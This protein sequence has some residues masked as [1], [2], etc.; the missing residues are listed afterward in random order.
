MVLSDKK[1]LIISYTFPPNDGIGGR[2]WAKFAKY[3]LRGGGDIF[4]FTSADTSAKKSPWTKDIRA[5]QEKNRIIKVN[6]PYPVVLDSYPS[7]IWDKIKY[8]LALFY[9]RLR[10]KG[11]YYDRSTIWNRDL[12]FQLEEKIKLGYKT[13]IATGAPFR[14]LHHL[15][16]LKNKYPD[17]KLIADFRDPWT[18]NRIA[19]G[20]DSLSNNRM[21][22]EL[23]FELEIIQNF[24]AIVS[25][26]DYHVKYLRERNADGNYFTI[27]NGF[28]PED[29][30]IKE[31]KI[32]RNDNKIR[33]I[34]T[35]TLY[36]NSEYIFE[37]FIESLIELKI[38][39]LSL[40]NK[41]EF[42]F[43]GIKYESFDNY[44]SRP[45]LIK[46]IFHHGMVSLE[47]VYIEIQKADLCMLFLTDQLNYTKNTKFYEYIF[48]RKKI[49]VFSSVGFLEKYVVKN[50]IGYSFTPGNIINGFEEIERNFEDNNLSAPKRYN[51]ENYSVPVILKGYLKNIL[52]SD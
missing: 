10:I 19:Y 48:M 39:N 16:I 4:V 51:V 18:N 29:C 23:Q 40:F 49:A 3:I 28:D 15:L 9:V 32:N 22:E 25:V 20:F 31:E 34:Y 41:L 21:K 2:R 47:K 36:T 12:L 52:M 5:L 27:P 35:G 44:F 46:S 13:I 30:N 11:N 1:L 14:Y 37:E 42:H 8:R 7:S 33:L 26:D 50:K 38:T 6:N 43:Y 45:E 17:L 24:D